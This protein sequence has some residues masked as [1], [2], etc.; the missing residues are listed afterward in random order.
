M[1]VY[2]I[3]ATYELFR[4]YYGAPLRQNPAGSEIGA[5]RAFTRSPAALIETRQ[6]T[7]L[8]CAFD[9][10]IESFRNRLFDGYKTGEGLAS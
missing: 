3:D 7:H 4:A 9:H 10:V 1:I 8:G 2:L 6:I 5:A